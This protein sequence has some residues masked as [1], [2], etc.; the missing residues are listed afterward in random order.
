MSLPFAHRLNPSLPASLQREGAW[1]ACPCA[2]AYLPLPGPRAGVFNILELPA[3]ELFP[4]C[5]CGRHLCCRQNIQVSRAIRH[6]PTVGESR[7]LMPGDSSCKTRQAAFPSPHLEALC[8]AC[9]CGILQAYPS[10]AAPHAA[11]PQLVAG[12]GAE[13]PPAAS[14][15]THWLGAPPG[16]STLQS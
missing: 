13:Q 9:S 12:A 2:F 10:R 14:L 1:N 4:G 7:Q 8:A 16:P 3:Q 6:V 11:V 5:P 15:Q